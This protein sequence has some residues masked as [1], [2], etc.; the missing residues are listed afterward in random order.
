MKVIG[1]AGPAGSG[2]STI[3]QELSKQEDVVS[4]D[5]D[6]VAWESYRPRTSTYWRLV[7]RFGKDILDAEGSIDRTRLGAVVFSDERALNDLNAIVHPAVIDRLREIIHEKEACGV[8]VLLV[9]GVLLATSPHVD[10]SLFDAVIWLDVS[11]EIRRER[12]QADGRHAHIARTIQEPDSKDVIRINAE[13]SVAE[14]AA[15]V[16]DAIESV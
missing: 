7:S 4:I 8:Q 13:G 3:T 10:R 5:L 6:E 14:V 9:E 16:A 2:K 15:R 1:L 12:L 11:S